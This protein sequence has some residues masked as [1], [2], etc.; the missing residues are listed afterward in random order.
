MSREA[1]EIEQSFARLVRVER[2]LWTVIDEVGELRRGFAMA[3]RLHASPFEAVE[4]VSLGE[5]NR[6]IVADDYVVRG[7][8]IPHEHEAWTNG[9]LCFDDRTLDQLL[10]Q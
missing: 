2:D 1:E 4:D 5:I 7:A 3:A 6:V 10:W 9:G 8:V